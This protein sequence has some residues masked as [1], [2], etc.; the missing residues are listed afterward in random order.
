MRITGIKI[1]R[2]LQ[3]KNTGNKKLWTAVDKL[4]EDLQT[5]DPGIQHIHDVREDAD[6]VHSD[7][8]YFFDIDVHRTLILIEF[9][10]QGE[11]TIVWAGTHKEYE[12]IFKNNKATIE[13][14]LR[15]K[16]YID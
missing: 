8:F 14:W 4:I 13:K 5:F 11:A 1:L 2:K 16:G 10:D 15:S 3:K 6:R 9:D 12:T 7:G